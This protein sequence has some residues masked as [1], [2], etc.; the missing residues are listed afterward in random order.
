M[1]DLKISSGAA[2][3]I[4]RAKVK[5]SGWNFPVVWMV[6]V[7][8]ALVAGYLVY[9]SV[10]D[11]GPTITIKFKDGNGLKAGKTAIQYRGVRIGDVKAVELSDDLREVLVEVRLQRSV[12]SIAREGSIFWI[13]RLE[14][15]IENITGLGTVIA[16]SHIEV[17]PGTGEPKSEFVGLEKPPVVLEG[18]ELKLVLFSN[19]LGSLKPYTPVYYRGIEVG[20]VQAYQLSADAT[21]VDIHVFIKQR[22]AK[23][24]RNGS[25]FWE[26]SGTDVK[27]GLFS[28][29]EINMQSLK[30]LVAGG[31]AFATPDDP[32]AKVVK[33]GTAFRLYDAP[34]KEWLEWKPEIPNP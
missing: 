6:P 18:K 13:V 28:G 10:R 32:Q 8:A 22:Y 16:G 4:P 30:S 31:I 21:S 33:D 9:D 2:K 1:T 3:K 5:K 11:F 19:R 12:A 7:I 26:V 27:F 25:K 17:L 15:G 24:V 23:L 14:G 20:A 29:L 34:K